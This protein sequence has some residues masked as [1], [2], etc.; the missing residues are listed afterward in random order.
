M[1]S[2]GSI[3]GLGGNGAGSTF[4]QA[5]QNGQLTSDQA[6]SINQSGL[7]GV[8]QQQQFVNA[9]QAQNGVGN[10]ASVYNQLQGVANGTGPNPAAAQLAQSTGQNVA[11]QSALMAGQRGASQNAGLIARQAA[12]QGANT[13]QQAAGQA[14]TMQAN[15][16]LNALNSLGGLATQQVGQQ[17]NALNGLNSAA[18]G[19]QSYL[20]QQNQNA[21]QNQQQSNSANSS[22]AGVNAK[23][24]GSLLGGVLGGVGAALGA[25]GGEVSSNQI[26]S[27]PTTGSYS[28][29]DV[30]KHQ[31]NQQI[32]QK[33][34]RSFVGKSLQASKSLPAYSQ[35]G[36]VPALV[37]PN[38]IYLKPN[39]AQAVAKGKADPKSVGEKI[40]GKA[41]VSGDSLKNDTVKK[42]LDVGGVVVPRS[43]A[44]TG[45]SKKIAAF[46]AAHTKRLK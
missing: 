21:I 27:N 11:N 25:T 45:D 14:A 39:A 36:K 4:D 9:L 23:Q 28:S 30:E 19:Q 5:A 2:F 38:E 29:G 13:Q 7:N 33:G 20:N 42:D 12:Q 31:A 44:T 40:P 46:V 41:K 8:N 15:Q 1:G 26:G 6:S 37:S 32:N 34:P 18:Q 17:Q 24:Q 35:G 16:S 22:L 43:I 3:L 10:Q